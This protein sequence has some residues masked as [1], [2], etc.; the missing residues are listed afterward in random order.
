MFS[1]FLSA[2]SSFFLIFECAEFFFLFELCAP[3]IFFIFVGSA[4]DFKILGA[5]I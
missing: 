1:H 5:P 3:R 4:K 2:L